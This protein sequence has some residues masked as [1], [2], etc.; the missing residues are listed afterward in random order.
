MPDDDLTDMSSEGTGHNA[1]DVLIAGINAVRD[2]LND[3]RAILLL[4][5]V[6]LMVLNKMTGSLVFEGLQGIVRAW[7]CQP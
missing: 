1:A 4:S 6:V 5:V 2:I 3:W 7:K